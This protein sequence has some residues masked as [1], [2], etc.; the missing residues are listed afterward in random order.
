MIFEADGVHP[1][2]CSTYG[3]CPITISGSGL[4]MEEP[5]NFDITVDGAPCEFDTDAPYTDTELTCFLGDTS[6]V[7]QIKN[8]GFDP[9]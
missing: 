6:A 5:E 4:L 7:H 9:G 3:G 1:E 2:M 8:H